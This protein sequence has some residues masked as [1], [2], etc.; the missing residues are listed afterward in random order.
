MGWNWLYN[1][2]ITPYFLG[3]GGV[4]SLDGSQSLIFWIAENPWIE[5]S[6]KVILNQLHT[7]TTWINFRGDFL[8][9]LG[10]HIWKSNPWPI[11]VLS[12]YDFGNA[13][14]THQFSSK[15]LPW[16]MDFLDHVYNM[17]NSF[18]KVGRSL[19]LLPLKPIIWY[20]YIYNPLKNFHGLEDDWKILFLFKMIIPFFGVQIPSWSQLLPKVPITMTSLL[21]VVGSRSGKPWRFIRGN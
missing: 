12:G 5:K 6:I 4:D 8:W 9:F 16:H 1:F 7:L 14:G 15:Y 10:T 11:S 20:I 17:M 13:S 3:G 21:R 2:L 18:S 19:D